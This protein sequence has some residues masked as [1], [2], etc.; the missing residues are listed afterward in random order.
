LNVFRGEWR[1][2]HSVDACLRESR[3]SLSLAV[4][5]YLE[6]KCGERRGRCLRRHSKTIGE[7]FERDRQ[8]LLPLPPAPYDACDKHTTRVTSLSLVRY[9]LNDYSVPTRYG[10]REVLVKGYVD[11]VIVCCGIGAATSAKS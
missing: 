7:R 1:Q 5:R 8:A 2:K 3:I 6:R 9:R 4:A 11:E 10:H